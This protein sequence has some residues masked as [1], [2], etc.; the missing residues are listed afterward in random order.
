MCVCTYAFV[1]C[2]WVFVYICVCVCARGLSR[3][4]E[5]LYDYI[6]IY[7]GVRGVMVIVVGNG[8]GDSLGD[9]TTLEGKL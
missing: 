8:H 7:G 2:V 1:G 9:A 6:Y 3:L 4:C 5:C